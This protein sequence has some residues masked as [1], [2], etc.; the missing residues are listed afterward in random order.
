MT[1]WGLRAFDVIYII[2]DKNPKIKPVCEEAHWTQ[3]RCM[4]S[5]EEELSLVSFIFHLIVPSSQINIVR[6][7]TCL[8]DTSP[9]NGTLAY[10]PG[11]IPLTLMI[12]LEYVFILMVRSYFTLFLC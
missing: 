7:P 10:L 12:S 1:V 11:P 6:L 5:S 2:K 9:R 3:M 4:F 8:T